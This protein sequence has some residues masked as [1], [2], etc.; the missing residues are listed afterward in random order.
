MDQQ[1]ADA[2]P[3][4]PPM[5]RLV[6]LMFDA[7]RQGRDD[8]VPALLRAGVDIETMDARGYTPLVI[9]SYSGQEA[10]TALLLAEGARPDGPPG[11]TGNSALM[12][13]AF[14]G[15]DAIAQALIDAGADVNRRNGVGQ[16]ALMTAAMFGQTAIVDM[17]IAAGAEVEA[18]D[19]AGNSARS[20]AIAQGNAAMAERLERAGG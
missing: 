20:V 11:A 16:T 7:C 14:K 2:L 13:V 19:D 3:P 6:E 1:T 8:V 4:L 10:T 15:Y 5:E 12:G 17:L 18:R 9:A